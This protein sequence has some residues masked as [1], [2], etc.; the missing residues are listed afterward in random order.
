MEIEDRIYSV[1][2][3]V[4]LIKTN[5]E[6][7]FPKINV[8][9][10]ISNFR[11][12]SSGHLY[13]SI[14][15]ENSVI[16]CVMFKV[17][18]NK[19]NFDLKDGD[20]VIVKGRI[21]FYEKRGDIQIIVVNVEKG[22]VGKLQIKFDKLKER[23]SKEGLFDKE[24]KK[25]LPLYP[26]KIGIV[27]SP[28]GAALV[29]I[30]RTISRRHSGLHIL[31]YP[32]K[33]QGEGASEN[34]VEGIKVF[35]QIKGID[36]I[37]IGRGG[38]SIEDLWAFNEEIVARAVFESKIPVISA[39]GHEIDFT[40]SDFVADVR[41]ATPS[42]AA[43]IVI[44]SRNILIE[45]INTYIDK[46]SNIVKL[47]H[48]EYLNKLNIILQKKI[49]RD[50]K[51]EVQKKHFQVD[52]LIEKASTILRKNINKNKNQVWSISDRFSNLHPLQKAEKEKGKL[53]RLEDHLISLF[54]AK[55]ENTR[56]SILDYNNKIIEKQ[57]NKIRLT[58]ISMENLDKRLDSL[59]YKKVL[60][61]GYSIVLK[62]DNIVKST[63]QV[64]ID[65]KID[66][67]LYKGNLFARILDKKGDKNE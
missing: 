42:S 27:T 55:I 16:R 37:I 52:D 7:T 25:N 38:G 49:F 1:S 57:N 51:L 41:A 10:E 30:L 64:E 29:D 17:Y 47:K 61:R 66:I 44:E 28:D 43:E 26:K 58:R 2:E 8:E 53:N 45:K 12:Y 5:L 40:I 39:V 34:I 67:L 20:S 46:L 62:D 15:D 50:F 14:K 22:G 56:K 11:K 23:L 35:N 33:V 59:S 31:I 36:V 13:F 60:E 19:L 6:Y 24:Y 65:D 63:G 9:G 32:S 18:A 3:L 48:S 21:S 54:K 4:L